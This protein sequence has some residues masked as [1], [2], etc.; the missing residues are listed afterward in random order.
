MRLFRGLTFGLLGLAASVAAQDDLS[1]SV[2]LDRATFSKFIEQNEVVLTDCKLLLHPRG[3]PGLGNTPLRCSL[4]TLPHSLRSTSHRWMAS[5]ALLVM[6]MET[7]YPTVGESCRSP[8]NM[9]FRSRQLAVV[10]TL[11]EIRPQV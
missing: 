8:A 3:A 5:P 6:V 9:L 4:L 11:P 7:E 1:V 2:E 10:R